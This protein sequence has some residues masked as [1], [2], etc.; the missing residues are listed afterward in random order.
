MQKKILFLLC[1]F[2]IFMIPQ[3]V[4]TENLDDKNT[5]KKIIEET[6]ILQDKIEIDKNA[7]QKIKNDISTIVKKNPP[8]DKQGGSVF[9]AFKCA[10]PSKIKSIHI[11]DDDWVLEL[12]NGKKFYWATGR[13]LPE[14]LKNDW[15]K[16]DKYP[17]YMYTGSPRDPTLF[18][19]DVIKEI[20]HQANTRQIS[21]FPQE[22]WL[23]CALFETPDRR[24]T[25]AKIIKS[26]FLGKRANIHQEISDALQRINA[27]IYQEA[28]VNRSVETF[29]NSI[30]D[31]GG[32][33]WRSIARTNKRSNH[34]YGLAIDLV[35]KG[36]D[37]IPSFWDW[38]RVRND[39][40]LTIPQRQLW[41]PPAVV[42][43]FFKEEGFIWG[44]S[45]NLYDTMHFEYR[46]ELIELAHFF[47]ADTKF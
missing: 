39:K 15:Q 16:Y 44:G 38:E 18:S 8:I 14:Q 23:F 10:Y 45:W 31:V 27:K 28:E 47:S 41:Q 5:E 12:H 9:A 32:Y 36:F 4:S 13:I 37:R 24:S 46:P 40:W 43:D 33:N 22:E 1:F 29:I 25:E 3:C 35:F 20:K 26:F 11:E 42:I 30:I 21:Y 2:S 34:S 7:Y 19:K 6:V 17:L